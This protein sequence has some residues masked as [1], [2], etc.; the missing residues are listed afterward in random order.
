M[1]NQWTQKLVEII[2]NPALGAMGITAYVIEYAKATNLK[3]GADF[4]KTFLVLPIIL[5]EQS[6]QKIMK[7]KIQNTSGIVKAIQEEP[8]ILTQ[9]QERLDYSIEFTCRSIR[10]A[11]DAGLIKLRCTE[12]ELELFP[13][14]KNIS[15]NLKNLPENIK[16]VIAAG[17]RL[18]Y[19][20]ASVDSRELYNLLHI[21]L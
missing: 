5:H 2:H 3:N 4:P 13:T 18:G 7:R 15:S 16:N 8:L 17:K 12:K 10:F 20:F 1:N 9:L 21:E 14:D 6:V 11:Y 19:W